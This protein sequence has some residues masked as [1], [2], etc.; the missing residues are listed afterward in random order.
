VPVLLL[1]NDDGI[2]SAGIAALH[3]ALGRTGELVTIAPSRNQSA[4]ARGITIHRSLHVKDVTFGQGAHGYS[5]DGAPVDCVR[6]GVAG[7]VCERPDLVVSGINH[8][9][10]LGDDVTYSGT[11]AAALEGILLGIPSIAVS[12]AS[13]SPVHVDRLALLVEPFVAKILATGL[14]PR[15]LLNINFPDV[16]PHRIKGVRVA[17]L[18]RASYHDRITLEH[19]GAKR[20]YTVTRDEPR[21]VPDAPSDFALVEAGYVSLTPIHFDLATSPSSYALAGWDTERMLAEVLREIRE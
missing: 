8:G 16:E 6:I 5:V 3:A 1:T 20:E 2:D 18:G 9:G 12:V 15:T 13:T 10:N 17:S 19:L 14:P 21:R 7:V 11:V 4:I